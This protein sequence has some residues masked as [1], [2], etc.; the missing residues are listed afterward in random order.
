MPTLGKTI[1]FPIF[2]AG[3]VTAAIIDNTVRQADIACFF[4]CAPAAK[5]GNRTF[6]AIASLLLS[7]PPKAHI[8][9]I[10]LA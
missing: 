9:S 6:A 2:I 7:F 10:V 4:Y 1:F 8:A 3:I 5:G